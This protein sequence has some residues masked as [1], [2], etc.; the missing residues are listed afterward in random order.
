M[1]EVKQARPGPA[2]HGKCNFVDKSPDLVENFP[3][4]V[5]NLVKT[6]NSLISRPD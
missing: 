1:I 3:L 5:E 6:F 2:T 4:S